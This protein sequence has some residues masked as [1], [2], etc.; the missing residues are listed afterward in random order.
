L[1]DFSG[2]SPSSPASQPQLHHP[3]PELRDFAMRRP[4]LASTTLLLML[5][6]ALS[7][8]CNDSTAEPPPPQVSGETIKEVA[9]AE[10][11]FAIDLYARLSED[12]EGENLFFSPHSVYSVMAMAAEGADGETAEQMAKVLGLELEEGPKGQFAST[13]N[14]LAGLA[15]G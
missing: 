7:A 14:G 3:S 10:Q 1:V 2:T 13:H 9:I 5:A 11:K 12:S 6:A 4:A 8:G 15:Y